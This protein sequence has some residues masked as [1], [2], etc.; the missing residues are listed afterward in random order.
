VITSWVQGWRCNLSGTGRGAQ[1]CC[2]Y[3]IS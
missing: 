3:F 2:Y 1:R